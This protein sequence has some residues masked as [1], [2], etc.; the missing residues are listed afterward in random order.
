MHK[1]AKICAL[2]VLPRPSL[3]DVED[4]LTS[5]APH[6]F[7]MH[8]AHILCHVSRCTSS[9]LHLPQCS[10]SMASVTLKKA[11]VAHALVTAASNRSTCT[12]WWT[13]QM[14]QRDKIKSQKERSCI[15]I[16]EAQLLGLGYKTPW[17]N[18][19]FH[20]QFPP[21]PLVWQQTARSA[22]LQGCD[23]HS[24]L[25]AL[26][27]STT[28][29]VIWGSQ[30]WASPQ[31]E[32]W[33]GPK[34]YGVHRCGA[35]QVLTGMPSL[36]LNSKVFS[37]FTRFDNTLFL[38]EFKSKLKKEKPV[39][40]EFRDAQRYPHFPHY[41]VHHL[42]SIFCMYQAIAYHNLHSHNMFSEFDYFLI[43]AQMNTISFS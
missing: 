43:F 15:C 10:L 17:R 39:T 12:C 14:V 34:A 5:A 1:S 25:L 9:I 23:C 41:Q 35:T 2:K 13:Q 24:C 40:A 30:R 31:P 16:A 36:P 7:N 18:R 8:L 27:D 4:G 32:L 6:L 38:L 28:K 22:S 42:K 21:N 20:A 19:S 29:R 3:P 26:L 33:T 11:K 37:S